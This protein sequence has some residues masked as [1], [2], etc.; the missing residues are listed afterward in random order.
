MASVQ[1][2]RDALAALAQTT[3]D[4]AALTNDAIQRLAAVTL[5]AV[6]TGPG[7]GPAVGMT[8][9]QIVRKSSEPTV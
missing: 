1:E 3:T 9:L 6:S 7:A 8:A 2:L 5:G 4:Q